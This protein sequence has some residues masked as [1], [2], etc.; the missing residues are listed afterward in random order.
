MTLSYAGFYIVPMQPEHKIPIKDEYILPM[1]ST[2][3]CTDTKVIS[4]VE[5]CRTCRL[6]TKTKWLLVVLYQRITMH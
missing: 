2:E 6:I 3:N 1:N 4:S 5:Y